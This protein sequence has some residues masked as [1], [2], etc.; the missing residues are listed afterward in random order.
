MRGSGLRE[1]R[2]R[3]RSDAFLRQECRILSGLTKGEDVG[4]AGVSLRGNGREEELPFMR[5][6]AGKERLK[7]SFF[8]ARVRKIS[9]K[10]EHVREKV[11]L[12]ILRHGDKSQGSRSSSV[13]QWKRKERPRLPRVFL[14]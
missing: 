3:L 7:G 11:L 10:S 1:R 8:W 13:A 12:R 2:R 6:M 5:P 14:C 9:P 4:H